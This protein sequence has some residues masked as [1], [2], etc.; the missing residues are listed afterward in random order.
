MRA[1]YRF[2]LRLLPREFRSAHAAEMEE[3]FLESLALTRSRKPVACLRAM[4]DV[5]GLAV[6]LRWKLLRRR[7]SSRR[8]PLGGIAHDLAIALRRLRKAPAF[9]IAAT[10]TLGLGIGSTVLM[11]T[12]VD[13]ILIRPLPYPDSDRMVALFL[14]EETHDL[15][16]APT[17]PVNFLAWRSES[18]SLSL[19]T[20]AH[21]WSPSLTGG[22]RPDQLDGLK[23]TPSL[24]QLVEIPPLLGR[25]LDDNDAEPGGE[26][27]VVLGYELWRER[28]GADPA[29]LGR[30]LTLDGEAHRVVGVMPEG[31][32]FPPFWFTEARMWAPLTFTPEEAARHARFLRVFAKRNDGASLEEVRAEMAAIGGRLVAQYPDRNASTSVEVEPL[33]EPVVEGARPALVLLLA[34]VVLLSLIACA[35]VANLQLARASGRAREIALESAL[36]A[37]RGRLLKQQFLES[38]VL[39]AAGGLLGASL[40]ALGISTLVDLSP[41]RLPRLAELGADYRVLLFALAISSAVMLVLGLV[42]TPRRGSVSLR[43]SGS[44]TTPAAGRRLR[45]ALVIGQVATS[46][47]LLVAAGLVLRSFVALRNLDPG[48]RRDQVITSSLLLTGTP[49]APPDRQVVLFRQIREAVGSL[50]AVRGAA[51]INHLPIGGDSWGI[52]YSLDPGAEGSEPPRAGLRTVTHD[53]FR[54]MG[55]RILAGRGF[56]ERDDDR[57]QNVVIVNRALAERLASTETLPGRRLRIG[58]GENDDWRTVV[59]VV[60]DSR[61]WELTEDIAPEIY[62]PYGQNPVSSYLTTTLVVWS[63]MPPEELQPRIEREVWSIAGAIPIT[64]VRTIER[65]LS[66]QMA[67][68]R[69][70]AL[71]FGVF[72]GM[73]LLLA[74]VGLYG[75]LSYTVGQ[76]T[77]EIGIRAA[78][79]A[80]RKDIRTLVLARGATLVGAGLLVGLAAAL[81]GGRLLER[82]LFGVRPTDPATLA[83]V[84]AFLL[85]VGFAATY[86]PARRAARLDPLTAL[87]RE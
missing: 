42:S 41:G 74:S 43:E 63:S 8:A 40:A 48:F 9:T 46:A 25:A 60:A 28:F 62:F 78:L 38:L 12:L 84:S 24:F 54:V 27:V 47:L 26:R 30:M 77:V 59:G 21:P 6:R 22:D 87:R 70:A 15:R 35:N 67:P 11:L 66:G 55:V 80:T 83:L 1:L 76:R 75:V 39:T 18:R 31:F 71:L 13:A 37:G 50:A 82:V 14:R 68:Q 32:R 19:M 7:A 49:H 51:F 16:H 56:D 3:A 58:S 17:S 72:A 86:L 65:I 79:G 53:Y 4:S 57:S 61:Q 33:L 20:A 69:F 10:V 36:G 5:L 52:S 2:L 85:L 81:L 23:V 64:N 45:D 44:R 29:M 34:A 73:A